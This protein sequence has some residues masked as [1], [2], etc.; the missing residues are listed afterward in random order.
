MLDQYFRDRYPGK[1]L[2]KQLYWWLA[3]GRVLRDAAAVL[4]TCEEER[5]R[6][7][8][9]F[10]GYSYRERVVLFGTT[11]PHGD[12]EREKRAFRAALPALRR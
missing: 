8:N 2:A 10:R 7:R 11:D 9:V 3:E 1:H 5:I 12:E 6:A 4:F